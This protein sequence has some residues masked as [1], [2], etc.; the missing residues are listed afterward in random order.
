MQ[1]LEKRIGLLRILLA[2]VAGKQV[3]LAD[4]ERQYRGQLTRIVEFVVYREGD[5]GNALALMTD[6]QTKLDEVTQ[7]VAHLEMIATKGTMELEVLLLTKRVAEARSQLTQLEERQQELASRLVGLSGADR[8]ASP[9]VADD[10]A[11]MDDIRG[12]YDEVESEISRLN[13]LIT[14]ASERAART[15]QGKSQGAHPTGA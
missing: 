10:A 11:E 7:T 2:D 5:V 9:T 15:V 13:T 3:Q 8:A 14:E 6:V 4:M 12:I 1:E